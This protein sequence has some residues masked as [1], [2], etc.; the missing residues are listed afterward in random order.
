[1]KNKKN[2]ISVMHVIPT[3]SIGGAERQLVFLAN[4]QINQGYD[5][6]IAVRKKGFFYKN[7]KDKV[8][9]HIIGDYRF[10]DFRLLFK[11]LKLIKLCKPNII[12][13]WLPQMNVVGGIASLITKKLWVST[14]RVSDKYYLDKFRL[15]NFFQKIILPFTSTLAVN[16]KNGFLYWKSK[17]SKI[18]IVFVKNAIDF[19]L[20][21]KFQ[22]R[23]FVAKKIDF[24]SVGR[25]VNQKNFNNIIK[26]IKKIPPLA[27]I[28]LKIIGC[29]PQKN[30]MVNLIKKLN[31]QK[32][33][34]V[35][36]KDKNWL[37][38]IRHATGL[39][40]MSKFEGQP[41]VLL[42]AAAANCPL[43]ISD[44]PEH[45]DIFDKK[46]AM[47]VPLDNYKKLSEAILFLASKPGY[48][49]KMAKAARLKIKDMT[50]ENQFIT[51]DKIYKNFL[52]I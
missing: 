13:T 37:K 34:K 39:I 17:I 46:S 18:K 8:K 52:K 2:S 4:K 28:N 5:V 38:N 49:K 35:I 3:L 51:Y 41:N 50:I 16:S 10:L 12:Q 11:L 6:N 43:I 42:E 32:K 15:I 20:I 14:E 21:K 1:M 9:V 48:A 19:R 22:K 24:I 23:I 7:L 40:S 36:V 25:F 47:F 30:E 44:I 33:I 26:A 27:K 29:G 31:L 45:K